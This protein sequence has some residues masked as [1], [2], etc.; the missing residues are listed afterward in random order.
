VEQDPFS[1][2]QISHAPSA[3]WLGIAKQAVAAVK[4]VVDRTAKWQRCKRVLFT[5][6]RYRELVCECDVRRKREGRCGVVAVCS[7]YAF[8]FLYLLL[9]DCPSCNSE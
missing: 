7:V 3:K 9:R 8:S 1:L 4:A 5:R 2:V 6:G